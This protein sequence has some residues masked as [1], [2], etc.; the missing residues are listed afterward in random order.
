[1]FERRRPRAA[2]LL[3]YADMMS[4]LLAVFVLLFSMSSLEKEKYQSAAESLRGSLDKTPL[5]PKQQGYFEESSTPPV[6]DLKPLYES[7]IETFAAPTQQAGLQ[8]EYQEDSREIRVTF[9]ER[10]AFD[11]AQAELKTEF[12]D[13][14]GEFAGF[15]D[16][17]IVVKAIGHT[18]KL[19]VVGGRFTSNW[20]LSSA[21]AA[22]VILELVNLGIIQPEQGQAIGLADTQPLA[23][24]ES[25]EELA[26]NRRV[27][28]LI[29]PR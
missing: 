18:D 26:K 25:A 2:W 22:N 16:K 11:T 7:L 1:M 23:K 3:T 14:L 4:L 27:E 20:E 24:G 13:M 29:S 6:E 12:S 21:R 9:P 10:I 28:V 15:R 5:T 19:P 8:I 17:N